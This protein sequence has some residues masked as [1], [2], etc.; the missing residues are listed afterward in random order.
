M[1]LVK[2]ARSIKLK[3][4]QII[5]GVCA[6]TLVIAAILQ[7][8]LATYFSQEKLIQ[9]LSITAKTIALQSTA[10]IEFL[11]EDAANELLSTL[12]LNK[13]IKSACLYNEKNVLLA[14]YLIERHKCNY[15]PKNVSESSIFPKETTT[16]EHIES[17]GEHIGD[18]V[19]TMSL[20]E[21]Y[22]YIKQVLL[23]NIIIFLI[24]IT[25]A[26]WL[27]LKLQNRITKPIQSL[28]LLIQKVSNT[29]DYSLR[30]KHESRDEVGVLTH[31]FNEM[32]SLTEEHN[33]NIEKSRNAAEHANKVKT[34]FLAN[35]S[36]ELRTPLNGIIGTSELLM[37]MDLNL[38]QKDLAYIIYK[39][40]KTL[41]AIINDILDIAKI[42]AGELLLEPLAISIEEIIMDVANT[43][44][45]TAINKGIQLYTNISH[46]VPNNA[47][48]DP[49]RIRQIILNLVSNAIK[50][51]E[52]G[53][54]LIHVDYKDGS[55]IFSIKDTG[56]GI[57]STEHEKIFTRFSQEDNSTTRRFGG[58]GLGLAICRELINL[59]GGKLDIHSKKWSG[60]TFT[61]IVELEHKANDIVKGHKDKTD[62]KKAL[63]INHI[64]LSSSLYETHLKEL[65]IQSTVISSLE[66][67]ITLAHKVKSQYDFILIE[68]SAEI[69]ISPE[70]IKNLIEAKA[71][72][73][74]YVIITTAC[75][76]PL[77]LKDL[78]RMQAN[79]YINRPFYKASIKSILDR[80]ID[81]GH[82]ATKSNILFSHHVSQTSLPAKPTKSE[83]KLK[84]LIAE[85][86]LINQL[87]ITKILNR[88]GHDTVIAENGA[89]AVAKFKENKFDY[90][91]MDMQ[92]PIMDGVEATQEIRKYEEAHNKPRTKIIALTANALKDHH[93]MC[94]EAGMDDYYTKPITLAKIENMIV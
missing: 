34:E 48:G 75:N 45:T 8:S 84:I 47:V 86:D 56:I 62:N 46:N 89:I 10:A 55:Y 51:T 74:A 59:M 87:L 18:L 52:E 64:E 50:F 41:L 69:N 43:F 22:N 78:K 5:L 71:N 63:I 35:M 30:A 42:E 49:I 14:S 82:S 53:Y 32:L 68:A 94:L 76:N 21:V 36:H 31:G 12:Q 73:N 13:N 6:L 20:E 37:S 93:K 92:M 9:N 40:G 57:A 91:L 29:G 28:A 25:V 39:S 85:D 38:Q 15:N 67:A 27:A 81:E 4:L 17:H 70:Q 72:H 44:N 60:S 88:M 11:D 33:I 77:G 3:I 58:T 80:L 23:L 54:V 83:Q 90:I 16:I 66:E 61:V 7:I 1:K 24:L 19:L 79:A 65:G 2:K 26:Y